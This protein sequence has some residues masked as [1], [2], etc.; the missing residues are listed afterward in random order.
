MKTRFSKALGLIALVAVLLFS[1]G[2]NL[3]QAEAAAAKNSRTARAK[4]SKT[5][6]KRL[7]ANT[8]KSDSKKRL[9]KKASNKQKAPNKR[10]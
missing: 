5:G 4:L 7:A 8:K 10:G 6:S 9:F 2:I 3:P 1:L